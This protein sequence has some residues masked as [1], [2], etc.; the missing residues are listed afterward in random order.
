[1][2][3]LIAEDDRTSRMLLKAVLIKCGHEVIVTKDGNEAWAAMRQPDAPRLAILDWMMPGMNGI[4]VCRLVRA[5]DTQRP[6]YL[7]MLTAKDGK[8]D[9]V[10][11]L[12]AGADDYLA[13]PYDKTELQARV[14]VGA[15]IVGLQDQLTT[16]VKEL[17]EALDQV[18]TLQGIIPICMHCKRIRD[19][20]N[21]WQQVEEYV[22]AHSEAKF[23]HGLCDDC[24][25]KYYPEVSDDVVI[26]KSEECQNCHG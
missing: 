19:G 26:D 24:L 14:E 25:E 18:Q 3:I 21:Y 13:K 6:P 8:S 15:R 11:G 22:S 9:I 2:R 1:M 10:E 4:D 20:K 12:R 23:S 5:N 7:L 16:R 17:R